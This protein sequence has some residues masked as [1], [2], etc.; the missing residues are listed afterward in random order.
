MSD[1]CGGCHFHLVPVDLSSI[2]GAVGINPGAEAASVP[3]KKLVLRAEL[4]LWSQWFNVPT[5]P[6][7]VADD[8][9][10]DKPVAHVFMTALALMQAYPALTP[11]VY[12]AMWADGLDVDDPAVLEQLLCSAVPTEVGGKPMTADEAKAAVVEARSVKAKSVIESNTGRALSVGATSVPLFD[13]EGED[14]AVQNDHV[15]PLNTYVLEDWL[16]GWRPAE[17]ASK[18][19]AKL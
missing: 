8:S 4:D 12:H 18:A 19:A 6:E 15:T 1:A 17:Y 3:N 11:A 9:P 10:L 2:Q 16:C 13:V 14:I 7:K 5:L